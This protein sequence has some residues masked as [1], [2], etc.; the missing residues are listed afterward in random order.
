MSGQFQKKHFLQ[1]KIL[2]HQI[3]TEQTAIDT[4]DGKRS[5]GVWAGPYVP[6]VFHHFSLETGVLVSA[7]FIIESRRREIFIQHFLI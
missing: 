3:L 5:D 7:S 6:A 4:V 1:Y 2:R